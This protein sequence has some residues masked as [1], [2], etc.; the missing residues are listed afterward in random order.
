MTS[1][2]AASVS[3]GSLCGHLLDS[4]GEGRL[5]LLTPAL[6]LQPWVPPQAETLP[7]A[8]TVPLSLGSFLPPQAG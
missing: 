8:T 5:G 2:H 1:P 7:L 6:G 4:G 3:G